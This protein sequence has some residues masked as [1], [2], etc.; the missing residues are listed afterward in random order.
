MANR[1]TLHISHLPKLKLWLR[2]QGWEILPL[3]KLVED[4]CKYQQG[5]E[6][7]AKDEC[8]YWHAIEAL[9]KTTDSEEE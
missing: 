8:A 2:N 9:K 3:S 4:Q 5:C 6:K 1:Y 7:C